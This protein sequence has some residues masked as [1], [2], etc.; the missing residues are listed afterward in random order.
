M[1]VEMDHPHVEVVKERVKLWVEALRSGNFR[2]GRGYMRI[3]HE[4]S[5]ASYCCLGVAMEVAYANGCPRNAYA[6]WGKTSLMPEEVR[7]W[8]GGFPNTYAEELATMNDAGLSFREIANRISQMYVL[9][10][11]S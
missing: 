2:Q 6:N 3:E 1:S 9:G 10:G 8:Y 4:Y 11:E 7:D 5:S